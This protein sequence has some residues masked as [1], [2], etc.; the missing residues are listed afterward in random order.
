MTGQLSQE[1]RDKDSFC[2]E[3]RDMSAAGRVA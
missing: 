2:D 3:H 1:M